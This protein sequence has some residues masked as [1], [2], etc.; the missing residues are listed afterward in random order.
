MQVKNA[1]IRNY[2]MLKNLQL[3]DFKALNVL[4]GPNATGKSTVLQVLDQILEAGGVTLFPDS[5][6][7][8]TA[9][10]MVQVECGIT[11]D[12]TDVESTLGEVARAH[13]RPP[14]EEV[15]VDEY[16]Q[17]F[18]AA[19]LRYRYS[20]VAPRDTPT[21]L[22]RQALIH[23]KPLTEYLQTALSSR[24]QTLG[25]SG[26]NVANIESY[27]PSTIS[28]K[29]VYLSVNRRLSPT[30]GAGRARKGRPE[31]IGNWVMQSRG[32][33]LPILEKYESFLSS[34][35]PHVR[36]ML[37]DTRQSDF[38]L[39]LSE[40]DLPGMSPVANWSSGTSHLA[41][42]LGAMA[43]LPFS[44][45]ILAE[46]PELSLHPAALR[47]LMGEVRGLADSG[48]TQFF[49]T[50]HSDFVVEQL[51]PHAK[52]HALWRFSRNS[53]GSASAARCETEKEIDGALTSLRQAR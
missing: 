50:T 13:G 40:N 51:D 44:S 3:D 1:G 24:A 20:G 49:L 46:E 28:N 45:V 31:E 38:Q 2:G 10:E 12:R 42:F 25:R 11:L 29:T 5:A 34:L 23:D 7:R 17:V 21:G 33:K 48:Q 14:P 26:V 18:K 32:R 6:F 41:I 36:A 30:F 8:A 16:A 53:D 27:I 52:S 4:I 15:V 43:A 35:L 47:Q 19:E 22:G 37:V 39:G 9:S